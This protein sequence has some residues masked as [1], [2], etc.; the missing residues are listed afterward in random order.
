MSAQAASRRPVV[1][2]ADDEQTN[3]FIMRATFRDEPY[4]LHTFDSAIAMLDAIQ[5]DGIAPDLVLLDLM[6]PNVDGYESCRR[7]RSIRG[8]HRIPIIM[9][10]GLDGVEHVVAGLDAGADDYITKPFHPLEVRARVRSLLRIKFMG[11]ELELTN[12]FLSDQ[13]LLLEDQVRKRTRELE[14][15]NL[16][17][18]SSLEKANAMN[19]ADT[20]NHILRVCAY[21]ELLAGALQLPGEH[22]LKI[23]R[24]ASLHDVGKVGV[25]DTLLKKP[26]P[27]TEEEFEE[28]KRHTVMGY[29]IL[30]LA[31]AH[32]IARNIALCHHEKF[33]GK[34]YPL[35]IASKEIPLEAR[36]VA[37]ADVFDALTTRRCYKN[38]YDFELARQ[39]ILEQRGE[40]FDPRLV[41]YHLGHWDEVLAIHAKYQEAA[42]LAP[43]SDALPQRPQSPLNAFEDESAAESN[44]V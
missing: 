17:V 2:A 1:F 7:L 20:G 13:T 29:E 14:D 8:C 24:Y 41:D 40:H 30:D 25:P 26:G 38:A 42:A 22:V 33:N 35:G 6:M 16:G 31:R 9:V 3:L 10:T 44:V 5:K 19:D 36:I 18:V 15:I 12:R 23:R 28:M 32:P 43:E 11:D 37:L 21:S 39:I 34:G 4:D 27:L